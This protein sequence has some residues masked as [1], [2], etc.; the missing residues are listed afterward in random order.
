MPRTEPARASGPDQGSAPA[1][2]PLPGLMLSE[3]LR[4]WRLWVISIAVVTIVAGIMGVVPNLIPLLRDK[5]LSGQQAARLAG[6]IGLSYVAARVFAGSL[7]DRLW[8]PAVGWVVLSMP[9]ITCVLLLTDIGRGPWL[10]AAVL[11]I[12]V[13]FGPELET[14]SYL[15]SRYFGMRDYGSI[16]ALQ[17]T[18]LGIFGAAVPLLYGG[19]YDA[20]GS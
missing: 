2:N 1:V 7:L 6:S 9:F 12:G 14:V 19:L 16:F 18:L 13:G 3:A 4:S 8:A 11:L 15:I 17:N 20:T 10:I 5:G